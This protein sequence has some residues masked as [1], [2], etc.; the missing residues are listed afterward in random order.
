[1]AGEGKGGLVYYQG[2]PSLFVLIR[3]DPTFH[4]HTDPDP[5]PALYLSDANLVYVGPVV[6]RPTSAPF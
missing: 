2:R 1:M 5:D 4:F 6:N 3:L